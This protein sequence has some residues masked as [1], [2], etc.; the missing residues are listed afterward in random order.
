MGEWS[1][2]NQGHTAPNDGWYIEV[3]E[4]DFHMGI[5]NP[6]KI[7]LKKGQKFPEPSNDRRKW[8]K[9]P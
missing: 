1:E 3:G 9:M 5:T 7:H 6:R 8:K 2:F 4:K